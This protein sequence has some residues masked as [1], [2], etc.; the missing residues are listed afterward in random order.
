MY[1]MYGFVYEHIF[2]RLPDVIRMQYIFSMY[3]CGALYVGCDADYI[4]CYYAQQA[5][6]HFV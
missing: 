2:V 6:F 4:L 5:L 1:Q 3:I